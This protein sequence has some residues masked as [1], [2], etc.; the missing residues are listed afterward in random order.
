MSLVDP[1]DSLER[2][3][4]KLLKI[5]DALMQR[6]EYGTEQ[7]SA[8]Y[9]Q[10]ER[11]AL[12]EKRVRERTNELER[13]LDLLHQSNSQLAQANEET[14]AARRNLADA[15][16]TVSE[17]FAL[18]DPLDNL[19]MCNSRF[20]RDFKDIT[21]A[22]HP[23][24]PF[25]T[26]V[27]EISHS[28]YLALPEG[29]TSD[30]WA[31]QRLKSH[32]DRHV[33]FNVRLV[34]DRWLQVSEHRTT[35]GGTVVLQTDVTD[36][37]RLERQER[38]RLKDKQT[39]MIRATLDHLNQGVCVFDENARLV[40]W[41]RKIGTLLALPARR[42]QLGAS[43]SSLL[44]QLDDQIVFTR[45]IG[46]DGFRD[47]AYSG[48]PQ[49]PI[50]FE[51][52]HGTTMTLQVFGRGMPDQGFVISV[53]DVTAEREAAQKLAE[54]N[55]ILER[56]VVERTMELEDALAAA[57]RAN[58]SKSRF[59]AAASHDLLQPLSAAKLFIASLADRDQPDADRAVLSKAE[60]ALG[61]AEQIIDALLDISK[62]DSDEG[63]S[64]D[65][66]PVAL[67][68]VLGPLCDEGDVLAREHGLELR[69]VP[70]SVIVDTDPAYFRRIVQNLVSNAIRYTQTGKVLVGVRRIADSA[71][72]E[73]WDTGPGISEEDQLA[74]FE[75][76]RRLDPN[77][78]DNEGLGLGLAIVERACTRLGHALDLRSSLDAGSCFKVTVPLSGRSVRNKQVS[79][80][81]AAPVGLAQAGLV[82]LL[83]EN[84][85]QMRRALTVMLE[86]WGVHVIEAEDAES[87]LS[88]LEDLD[89]KPDLLLLDYQ[90]GPGPSGLDLFSEIKSRLGS[91]P[92]AIISAD[93]TDALKEACKKETVELLPKPLDRHKLGAFLDAIADGSERF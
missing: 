43:F 60:A 66:R 14:E 7:S 82:V 80:R 29:M 61:S 37:I 91:L 13:T 83:V 78:S 56:R 3:N 46:R 92:C 53:T 32:R 15:I 81:I 62:L 51:I 35:N 44:Q 4:E 20:C 85:T 18:F 73:V 79:R 31:E 41:N 33:M 58:A 19:V 1:T 25:G 9:V 52:K 86:S 34:H 71:R 42:L 88:L 27:Q 69:Y 64:F 50:S 28:K 93:R 90:L 6:V 68:D 12:L 63:I 84:E 55:E 16:E 59:V 21:E 36:L 40:G 2:Q 26:Y 30:K 47:W 54:I 65:V 45:G 70:S 10:F 87:A 48:R 72:I 77:A 38:D 89:L 5:A 8:A 67:D 49:G 76:F 39:R 24:L 23:G 17:G 22:L 11:A 74:I 57:E 75:E